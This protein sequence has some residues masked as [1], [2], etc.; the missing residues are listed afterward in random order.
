MIMLSGPNLYTY[1]SLVKKKK[2][3]K[4]IDFGTLRDGYPEY[5]F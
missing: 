4:D 2:G 5:Q 3:A 1:N